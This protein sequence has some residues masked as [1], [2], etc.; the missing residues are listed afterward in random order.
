MKVLVIGSTGMLGRAVMHE[1]HKRNI[2]VAGIARKAA[3]ICIDITDEEALKTAVV[4]FGPQVIINCAAMTSLQ[5]CM[6][7]PGEAYMINARSVASLSA[8]S[9]QIEA[10]LVQISTDHYYIG[11]KDKKHTESDPVFL[12]NEYA[13][14]KYAGEQFAL[15]ISNSL[16]VRTNIVG[17]RH[18]NGQPTFVE[19]II[20]ALREKT[21]ITLFEDFY[22]SSLDVLKFSSALFELIELRPKGILNVASHDVSNKAE[23]ITALASKLDLSLDQTRMGSVKSLTDC[24]RAESIGLDVSKAEKLLGYRFPG[25]KEVIE[26]LALYYGRLIK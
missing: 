23:F 18:I 25:F 3:D 11:D 10:Y 14:T 21:P 6:R 26:S 19:G 5:A 24:I 20:H 12:I 8:I 13:R 16:V 7:N 2:N 15:T 1:A 4:T 22:T 9:Q 17:F